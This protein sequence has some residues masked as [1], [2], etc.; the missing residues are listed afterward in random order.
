[1]GEDYRSF[2]TEH[3]DKALALTYD[4]LLETPG[5]ESL[6]SSPVPKMAVVDC[7]DRK[8]WGRL[9]W[10]M[11]QPRED[12]TKQ[13]TIL[14]HNEDDLVRLRLAIML[15]FTLILNGPRSQV[16]LYNFIPGRVVQLAEPRPDQPHILG[17]EIARYFFESVHFYAATLQ[18]IERAILTLDGELRTP[19]LRHLLEGITLPSIEKRGSSE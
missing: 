8:E 4:D 17:P 16:S 9:L 18:E 13:H 3:P 19:E 6:I 14:I 10:E 15:K 5:G 1:V 2:F 12:G 7:K 11:N